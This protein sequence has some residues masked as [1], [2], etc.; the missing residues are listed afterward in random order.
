M[1]KIVA[2]VISA[3]L[4]LVVAITALICLERIPAGYVG[5]VYS[6]NGGVQDELLTQG[7]HFVNPTKTVK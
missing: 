4:A 1:K 2:I 7:F 6:M 3:I 5:V